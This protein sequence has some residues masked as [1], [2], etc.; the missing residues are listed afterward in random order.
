MLKPYQD[1]SDDIVH[2]IIE[3]AK[4]R[5][6]DEEIK[7]DY[8]RKL[9]GQ[10][11]TFIALN[12]MN[13]IAY[14]ASNQNTIT[15]L[16]DGPLDNANHKIMLLMMEENIGNTPEFVSRAIILR[17]KLDSC[18]YA[19]MLIAQI[20]RKHI[21]YTTNI[22]HKQIDRLLSGKVMSSNSKTRLLLEQGKNSK[23]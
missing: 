5:M 13:D 22:D 4:E 21:I 12:I 1:H 8:V 20:A 16:R 9:L 10:A 19:R 11:G 6:P 17:K 23:S 15:A 3:F 2:S 7:E 18:P 14:N